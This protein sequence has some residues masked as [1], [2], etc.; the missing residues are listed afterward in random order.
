MNNLHLF[1]F[2]FPLLG[3]AWQDEQPSPP[4]LPEIEEILARLDKA[5]GGEAARSQLESL[6]LKGTIEIPGMPE[7]F[8]KMEVEEVHAAGRARQT[9][10]SVMGQTTMTMTMGT[11]GEWCWSSDP[12]MGVTIREG[13]EG[14]PVERL[15][16]VF[17]GA[18]TAD[19]HASGEVVGRTEVDG[20]ECFELNLVPT[21][22]G[23]ETW[24]VDAQTNRLARCDVALPNPEPGG[25]LLPMQFLFSDYEA[26]EGV[27]IARTRKQI[28][29]PTT[30]TYRF[31]S[32]V[33]NTEFEKRRLEPPLEVQEAYQDPERKKAGEI[34][35]DA[36]VIET[37]KERPIASIRVTI[38]EDQ[39]SSQLAVILPEVWG[40]LTKVGA[41]MDGPPL[42]RVWEHKDGEIDLEAGI[43]VKKAIEATDRIL[44]STL[45]AGRVATTW[46]IGSY[47]ELERTYTRL[48]RWI[49][50]QGH[51]KRAG[52][53][54]IYWTDPGIEPDPAKWRTQVFW[55]IGD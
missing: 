27:Q 4:P 6:V 15:F 55:P 2:L 11:T 54:E 1:P 37:L 41:A 23:P 9:S 13:Q 34:D 18:P 44:A 21:G 43:P 12:A 48:E 8:G 31:A 24:Y 14:A 17:R 7:G 38:P 50:E 51:T 45:P 47:H 26:V 46:H 29:G 53:W 49:D 30:L 3:F 10:T 40:H 25:G 16:A 20:R 35:P 5:M 28:I 33:A 22:G 42:T 32:A 19:L 39:I 36:V 52:H